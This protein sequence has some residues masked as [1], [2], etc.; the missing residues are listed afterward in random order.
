LARNF[1][2]SLNSLPFEALAKSLPLLILQKHND[3]L[4]QL[5]ALLFGQAGMLQKE[6]PENEYY[7]ALQ[8]E[9]RFLQTK[10]KLTPIEGFLWKF[11]R[12]RPVNFPT[13]RIAQFA[14]LLYRSEPLF[15]RI[16]TAKDLSA[17]EGV[18]AMEASPFWDNHYVF[19]KISDKRRK[20][21]G[22]SAFL[23]VMINTVAPFLFVYGKA[24]GKED[25]CTRAVELLGQLPAE[26]NS[27]ITRWETL[28]FRIDNAFASQALLQLQNEYCNARRC[29]HCAFGNAI[30][31]SSKE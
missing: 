10:Y 6:M 27:I 7:S 15:S 31:K 14:A 23:S 20:V 9:Y 17:K 11:L 12:L 2:F 16:I 8:R 18:F 24:R 30:V 1:G 29:L 28:G 4:Q 22:K 13:L 5:E 19:E 25:D 3:N 21:F 26:R